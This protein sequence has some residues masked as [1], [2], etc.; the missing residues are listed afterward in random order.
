[1]EIRLSH[2]DDIFSVSVLKEK[3]EHTISI[4]K[5]EYAVKDFSL[6]G[7]QLSF[8]IGE[9]KFN[10]Y[11]VQ[12]INRS[13]VSYNGEYYTIERVRASKPGARGT[14]G[15]HSGNV[16]SPM[17]GLLVKLSVSIGDEVSNGQILAIV[18]AMKM[19]NEL[20]APR[21]GIVEKVNFKEGAQIDAFQPIVE[22]KP[23]EPQ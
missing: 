22:L 6:N 14:S 17:P 9:R 2:L 12:D 1:M 7:C 19:Q 3:G 4:D 23:R 13:Y 11:I 8:S 21:D 20:R 5:T 10:M 16:S 15:Q 18:E